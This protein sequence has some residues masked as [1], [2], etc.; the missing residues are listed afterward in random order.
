[1]CIESICLFCVFVFRYLQFLLFRIPSL[2]RQVAVVESLVVAVVEAAIEFSAA[3]MVR[4]SVCQLRLQVSQQALKRA[5][6][7]SNEGKC[8]K[9]NVLM[10]T[11]ESEAK[12]S[13]AAGF[14]GDEAF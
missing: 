11:G 14:V 9:K 7:M 5:I 6:N 1:M 4:I 10:I 8:L 3:T 12:R 2:L 13:G